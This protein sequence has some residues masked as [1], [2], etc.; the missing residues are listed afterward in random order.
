MHSRWNPTPKQTMVLEEVYSNGTRTPTTQQ[1]QEIASK[2]QN[3]G[4]IEGKN[5]FYWFQNHKSR[6]KLKRRRGDQ[7]EVTTNVHEEAMTNNDSSSVSRRRGDHLV[8]HTRTCLSSSPTH[9]QN[10]TIDDGK[11]GLMEEKEATPQNQIHSINT[12]DFNYHLMIVASKRSQEAEQ[13]LNEEEEETRK[14]RTLDL[15]PVTDNQ[16]RTGFEGK[17]RKPDQLYSNYCYSY[18]FMPL[19]D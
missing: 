1:I 19:M 17:N 4:R 3:Y 10:N 13:Q 5:V 11:R 2:L 18:E 16:E 9:P 15:F 7:Q 6:E 14:S 8:I 12:S